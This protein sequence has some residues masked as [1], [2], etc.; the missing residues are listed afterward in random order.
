MD[1]TLSI[2]ELNVTKYSCVVF[3]ITALVFRDAIFT[4]SF[5][6]VNSKLNSTKFQTLAKHL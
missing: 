4:L 5:R 6:L 3:T 1:N 2:Y